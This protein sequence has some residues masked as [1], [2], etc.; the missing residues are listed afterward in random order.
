MHLEASRLRWPEW[1][2]GLGA[3]LSLVALFLL[4]WYTLVVHTPPPGQR[5]FLTESTNGWHGV[6]IVRWLILLMILAA[7]AVVFFQ[8]RERAPAL[9]MAFTV[10]AAPLAALTVVGL[11]IRV[12]IA[13]HGGRGIGGWVGL[14]GAAAIAYGGYKSIRMEGIAAAD[15]PAEIPAVGL[16]ERASAS[17]GE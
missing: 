13:P 4:P 8:A 5:I 17:S 16:G 7:F 9:P 3:L 15:G 1:I 6:A 14:L 12:W 10:I 2:I 11:I